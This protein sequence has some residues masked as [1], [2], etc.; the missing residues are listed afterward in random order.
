[1]LRMIGLNL[2]MK[3]TRIPIIRGRPASFRSLQ[4]TALQ[5]MEVTMYTLT[6]STITSSLHIIRVSKTGQSRQHGG[7]ALLGAVV[8][9]YVQYRKLV[10]REVA[11]LEHC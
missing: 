2:L 10:L 11:L 6:T 4:A 7:H 8:H 5:H 3:R 9:V 1:M